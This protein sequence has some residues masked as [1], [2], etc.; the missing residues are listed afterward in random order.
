MGD[1]P[2]D[3]PKETLKWMVFQ[4]QNINNNRNI[5][6]MFGVSLRVWGISSSCIILGEVDEDLVDSLLEVFEMEARIEPKLL[7]VGFHPF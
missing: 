7:K 6:D 4:I 1:D 3:L 2:L 5:R